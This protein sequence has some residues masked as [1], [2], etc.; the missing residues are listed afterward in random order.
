MMPHRVDAV[1]FRRAYA[2][3]AHG[4]QHEALRL[5]GNPGDLSCGMFHVRRLD[6][7]VIAGTTK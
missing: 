7:K 3:A 5:A 6:F 1:D 2:A 4:Q